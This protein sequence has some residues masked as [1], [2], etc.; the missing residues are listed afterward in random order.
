MESADAPHMQNVRTQPASSA[1]SSLLIDLPGT[2]ALT[3]QGNANAQKSSQG[4]SDQV[5]SDEASNG[6]AKAVKSGGA[7][8]AGQVH[9]SAH[10]AT[11]PTIPATLEAAQE[12]LSRHGVRMGERPSASDPSV[13]VAHSFLEKTYNRDGQAFYNETEADQRKYLEDK[14]NGQ[15]SSYDIRP[16]FEGQQAIGATSGMKF[17]SGFQLD[18]AT[19]LDGDKPSRRDIEVGLAS[20]A[21]LAHGS[22]SERVFVEVDPTFKAPYVN[23]GFERFATTAGGRAY[24]KL[25]A[26]C[27]AAGVPVDTLEMMSLELK[28]A[29]LSKAE[30]ATLWK[31]HVKEWYA[32]NW[33]GITDPKAL[34][35]AEEAQRLMNEAADNGRL[36]WIQALPNR[37]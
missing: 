4:P 1:L 6:L 33:D 31:A 24:T 9:P 16:L 35:C 23:A 14:E 25:V 3:N 28:G 11:K 8:Q 10:K 2:S 15:K 12:T 26:E 19:I 32:T 5:V 17:A 36:I 30:K 27:Q 21:V 29:K 22:Q 20:V 37:E 34:K 13:A 18:Y 7:A